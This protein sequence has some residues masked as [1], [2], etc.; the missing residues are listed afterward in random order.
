LGGLR[1]RLRDRINE[2]PDGEPTSTVLME[3]RLPGN[4]N[5]SFAYVEGESLLM[6]MYTILRF[7]AVRHAP[8]RRL[9]H[10]M[11]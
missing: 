10:L 4:L 2:P 8:P 3:H 7:P 6:G 9:S 11:Y 5:I 1:D